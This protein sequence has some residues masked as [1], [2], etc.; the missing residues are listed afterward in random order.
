MDLKDG[1]E[2]S[3]TGTTTGSYVNAMQLA[4]APIKSTSFVIANTGVTNTMFYKVLVYRNNDDITYP[5]EYVPETSIGTSS[6]DE[7]DLMEYGISKVIV[8]VKNN[9]GATTYAI[10]GIQQRG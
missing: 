5:E 2:K 4:I 6:Q 7:V 9:A 10:K 1:I 8:Q 3:A